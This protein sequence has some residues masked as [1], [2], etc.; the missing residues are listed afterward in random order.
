MAFNWA[1]LQASKFSRRLLYFNQTTVSHRFISSMRPVRTVSPSVEKEIQSLDAIPGPPRLPVLGSAWMLL[2]G[3]LLPGAKPLGKRILDSQAQLVEQYGKIYRMQF[4]GID[5]VVIADPEDVGKVLRAEAKYPKRFDSPILDFYRETHKKIPGVFFANGKEWHKHRSVI[6]KRMLRPKEVADYVPVLNEIIT[7]FIARLRKLRNPVGTE[8]ENEILDLDNELFKWSFESVADVVFDRRF[9]CLE[10]KMN[11]EAQEFINSIGIFLRSILGV[12]LLP[13]RFFKI[14]KTQGY[15]N[16]VSSY[17]KMYEYAELF[18]GRKIDELREKEQEKIE[19]NQK[20]GFFEFLL[21]SGKLT[22]DDLLASVIDLLFA[23]VD[24]TSNTMQWALYLLSKNPD[25]QEKLYQE[26]ASVLQPG[27]QPDAQSLAQMPYLKACIRE[28]LRLY[29]VLSNMSR[30][31]EEDII[32][33][34]YRIPA[35]TQIEFA[36]YYMSRSEEHFPDASSFKPERWLRDAKNT[37]SEVQYPFASIPFGF[38]TRMCVGR[39]IAELEMHLLLAQLVQQFQMKY[40]PGEEVEP[41]M[42][43]VTIPDRAV[44]V[45]FEDRE[46]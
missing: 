1:G 34:G 22:E 23:G 2:L 35:N 32:L 44:R 10:E 42:R 17:D 43:G 36:A 15:K 8:R 7:D 31:L 9:G 21:S 39:R 16:F 46:V 40:P 11:Q 3:G 41:F 25:K 33:Q 28:T 12:S 27:S 29:P 19:D 30:K 45:K 37:P 24:T 4:P 14:Y 6:S 26:I 5:M 18:I 13:V 38:G 20:V